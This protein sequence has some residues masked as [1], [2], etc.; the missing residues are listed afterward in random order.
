MSLFDSTVDYSDEKLPTFNQYVKKNKGKT[1]P[2]EFF[3]TKIW[4]PV[5]FDS[6]GIETEK[7]RLSV[8]KDSPMGKLLTANVESILDSTNS[9]HLVPVVNDLGQQQFTFKQGKARVLWEIMG[10]DTIYGIACTA[11]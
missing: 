5:K 7:F 8:P 6:F 3:I 10:N 4:Y 1:T 2:K 9:V 11:Q